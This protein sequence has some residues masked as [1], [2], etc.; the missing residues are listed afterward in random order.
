MSQYLLLLYHD[1][2]VAF[3]NL[4]PEDRQRAMAKY[5][6]YGQKLIDRKAYIT[7]S[8]LADEPG[9]VMRNKS[10][11]LVTTDGPFG[12]TKEWLGG[13]YLIEAPNYNAAVELGRE[14]PHIEYGGTVVAR[15]LDPMAAAR[16]QARAS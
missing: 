15:E 14:C 10:G 13:F 5:E 7:G 8:K 16:L 4:A 1:N 9:K 3:R 6:A 12:E 11:R 2:P